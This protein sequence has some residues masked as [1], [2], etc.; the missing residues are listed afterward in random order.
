MSPRLEVANEKSSRFSFYIFASVFLKIFEHKTSQTI[1]I[2]VV[3][4]PVVHFCEGSDKLLQIRVRSNHKGS[5]RNIKS[6]ALG[7][8]R[9]RFV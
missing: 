3:R 9:E 2:A 7:R 4:S 6:T 5:H 8:E 1:E